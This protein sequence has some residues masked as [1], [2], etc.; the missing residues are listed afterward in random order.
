MENEDQVCCVCGDVG[1]SELLV[2]C[3]GCSDLSIHRYCVGIIPGSE[4][5]TDNY[6]WVCES[7]CPSMET[8]P[9]EIVLVADQPEPLQ[10]LLPT[11][12]PEMSEEE[13]NNQCH[14]IGGAPRNSFKSVAD[15]DEELH[16]SR[17]VEIPEAISEGLILIVSSSG[18][19]T[20]HD[21]HESWNILGLANEISS[22]TLVKEP[23][24]F[25]IGPDCAR[26]GDGAQNDAENE[27]EYSIENTEELDIGTE[28]VDSD[29][30]TME[31]DFGTDEENDVCSS[32]ENM[33]DQAPQKIKATAI[34]VSQHTLRPRLSDDESQSS[35][36]PEMRI[37]AAVLDMANEL[38]ESTLE[39]IDVLVGPYKISSDLAPILGDVLNKY[40][41]IFHDCAIEPDTFVVTVCK[42]IQHLQSTPFETLQQKHVDFVRDA[43]MFPEAFG[44]DVKWLSKHGDY[45]QKIVHQTVQYRALKQKT[46]QTIRNVQLATEMADLNEDH[47]KPLEGG[48]KNG[49][50]LWTRIYGKS[51][52]DGLF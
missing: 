27:Q 4:N 32:E 29:S 50:S 3:A 37:P 34:E 11:S 22:D 10:I 48:M 16:S 23:D 42:T 7:C 35:V 19:I 45:L 2:Y 20:I 12:F 9:Y 26:T 30:K 33:E 41:D 14:H 13:T 38:L 44:V 24:T 25:V 21:Y 40:G 18:E 43:V 52:A 31:L 36:S 17:F 8:N 49:K 1:F 47:L 46:N 15:S 39:K 51:L 5:D 6:Y 28:E